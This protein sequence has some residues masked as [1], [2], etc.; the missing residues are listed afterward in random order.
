VLLEERLV[1]GDGSDVVAGLGQVGAGGGR[2]CG[3]DALLE[4]ALDGLIGRRAEREDLLA[5]RFDLLASVVPG[6]VREAVDGELALTA[7][8]GEDLARKSEAQ[9]PDLV[10]LRDQPH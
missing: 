6:E 9:G 2:G 10:D 8:A 3:D 5:S 4:Q 7:A 1:V